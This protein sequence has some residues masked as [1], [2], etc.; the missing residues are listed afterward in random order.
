MSASDGRAIAYCLFGPKDGRPVVFHYGT[1]GV[2]LLSPQ[3]LVPL[4]EHG[5]HLLVADRPGYGGSTRRPGR[6]VRDVVDDVERLADAQ[7]WETFATWGGSGGGPHALACAAL[8]PD[9]V[10]RCASV[11]GPAPFDA[12]GLDWFA[13]M[14]PGNI[15][16]FS[17][18]AEGEHVYRP[19]VERLATAAAAAME[20]GDEPVSP[21]HHLSESD[22]AALRERIAEPGYATRMRETY[23]G[24]VD[25]WID[26]CI[27][28]TRSWGFDPG[29]IGVPTSV[30]YG[31]SDVLSPRGHSDWLLQHIAA[32]EPKAMAGG[33]ILSPESLNDLY[34]W[35]AQ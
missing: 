4:V 9:R 8:L 12:E 30:W 24:G 19:L 26:D 3:A 15:E 7:G 16:E 33:H 27:A 14:S 1:P 6:S 17:A 34:R 18:A 11:V 20:A 5:V 31:S 10:I 28:M 2:R 22:L 32:A 25:G 35:L 13:D 23:L 21:D 29:A